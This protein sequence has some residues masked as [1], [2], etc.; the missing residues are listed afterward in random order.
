MVSGT[1]GLP[2]LFQVVGGKHDSAVDVVEVQFGS[3]FVI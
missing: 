1:F 3:L 2:S